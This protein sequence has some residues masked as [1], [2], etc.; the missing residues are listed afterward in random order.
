MENIELILNIHIGK[1]DR[2]INAC[3]EYIVDKK[4]KGDDLLLVKEHRLLYTQ[5]RDELVEIKNAFR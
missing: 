4:P 1:Y 5:F 3:L 2:A